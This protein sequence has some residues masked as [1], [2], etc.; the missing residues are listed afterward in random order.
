M[1][2]PD[3][4]MTVSSSTCAT[5]WRPLVLL[6]LLAATV[7]TGLVVYGGEQQAGPLAGMFT[8]DFA[9]SFEEMHETIANITLAL[10]LAHIAA[11]VLASFVLRENLIRSMVTGYKR[12]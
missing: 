11:V 1:R 3:R 6:V 8:K 7:A 10:V 9:E 12:R 2:F 5:A 4:L